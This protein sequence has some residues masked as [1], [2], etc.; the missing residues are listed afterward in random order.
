[1]TS[2]E[3][4]Q[5]A[6]ARLMLEHPYFGTI[7]SSLKL[8]KSDNVEAFIS[9]GKTLQYNDEYFDSVGVE[10]IEFALANGAMHT[11][12]KHEKR[13]G[14][15]YDWLW[16]LATDYTIN[17]ML[18]KNGLA[19]PE[20][21]N[22]QER[23]EKMYAEEV[24][25]ILRSEIINEE[26]SG[27]EDL[28]EQ[29]HDEQGKHNNDRVSEEG[30]GVEA[31]GERP[32]QPSSAS[33]SKKQTGPA[34]TPTQKSEEIEP[35]MDPEAEERITEEFFEQLFK[36]MNRQGTLPK[37]LK[38]LVPHYFSHQID[39]REMLYRY[40][41]SHAKSS[42]TFMPPNIKYLYRG[43]YLP[44][45]SSDL[46]RIV[47]AIDTSGS[48]DE[49]LL[50]IFLGEVQSTTQQYPNYEI[51]I[52]TADAKIQSHEV[53]LPGETLNYEIKGR[54]GTDFRPVFEYIDLTIDYPTL[55]LYFTDGLGTF[56]EKEPPYDLL[57][58]MPEER[59]VP[60]GETI[61]LDYDS[62]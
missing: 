30:K 9:D 19:L 41:A 31:D 53:F 10:D 47:V 18:V 14:E 22:Y 48:V 44:S 5:K 32:R 38:F 62:V 43:I 56:P 60:F 42:F 59:E 4:I 20:R 61:L 24:Y 15:R 7:V 13:A 8:E 1:M 49:K 11:V 23:F 27:D 25:E 3:K 34:D 33:N 51:D 35:E 39:W 54:G 36:K 50:G 6:K 46:L 58:I 52:I 29:A 45:L 26:L 40:I 12:L 21:A 37:D 16:Q 17:S 28:K 57:W 2:L 55:L